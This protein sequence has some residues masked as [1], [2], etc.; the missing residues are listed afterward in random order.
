[1]RLKDYL[2]SDLVL[3]GLR[4]SGVEGIVA[5]LADHLAE[6]GAVSSREEVERALLER[7]HAHS[8]ALGH[9]IA[10]PHATIAGLEGPV[11]LVATAD[12]PI[13]FG[14]AGTDPVRVFFVLLSPPGREREHVKLL[15]RICRLVRHPD[16]VTSLQAANSGAEAVAIIERVDEEHV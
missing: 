4:A 8:T 12:E 5:E 7:E 6:R 13:L 15:A 14:P 10:L 3:P 2:R 1:M 16:F 11:L 9:G